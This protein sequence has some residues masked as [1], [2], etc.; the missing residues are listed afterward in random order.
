MCVWDK[1]RRSDSTQAGCVLHRSGQVSQSRG[2]V[3]S[4]YRGGARGAAHGSTREGSPT[5]FEDVPLAVLHREPVPAHTSGGLQGRLWRRHMPGS[6]SGERRRGGGGCPQQSAGIEWEKGEEE[7]N[8]PSLH[9]LQL[10]KAA[11]EPPP[12][13]RPPPL[14]TGQALTCQTTHR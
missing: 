3:H 1:S 4:H 6:R 9:R 7:S 13:P 2:A 14:G 5:C 10:S 8:T 12:P 11:T